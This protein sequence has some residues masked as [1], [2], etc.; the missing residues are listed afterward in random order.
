MKLPESEMPA[1]AAGIVTVLRRYPVKSMQGETPEAA[2]ITMSGILGD[3][4]F[5]LIDAESGKVASAKNPRKWPDLLSFHATFIT[6]PGNG[7]APKVQITLPDGAA[8]TTDQGDASAILSRSLGRPVTLASAVPKKPVLEEYWPDIA[9]LPHQDAVTDE[10]MPVGTFFDCACVHVLT[11]ATLRRFEQLYP[12]GQ[13]E[14]PRFRP[15][16]VVDTEDEGFIENTWVGRKLKIGDAVLNVTGP[17]PRCMMT[18]LQQGSLPRDPNILRTMAQKNDAHA[19][20]YAIVV[21]PGEI[22]CGDTVT[23]A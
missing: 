20:V 7:K 14:L 23:L 15:N 17:T 3:R 21:A 6:P 4:A 13:W 12:E 16:I 5:A 2:T 19:G 1:V 9:E 18:T 22:R 11:T 8:L 10:A